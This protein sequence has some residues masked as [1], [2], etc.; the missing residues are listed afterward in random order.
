MERR[1]QINEK[2]LFSLGQVVQT[3]IEPGDQKFTKAANIYELLV[4]DGDY[5]HLPFVWG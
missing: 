5:V 3:L 1:R 2:V 4:V